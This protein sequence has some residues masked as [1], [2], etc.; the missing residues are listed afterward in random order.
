[1][2]CASCLFWKRRDKDAGECFVLERKDVKPESA[3][4]KWQAKVIH[5]R[6]VP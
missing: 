1:M 6:R 4:H 5:V 3:C 2:R